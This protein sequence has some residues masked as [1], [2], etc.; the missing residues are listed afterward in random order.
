MVSVNL[1]SGP[2]RARGFTLVE[3]LVVIAIIGVLVALLLPAVQAA[4]E[5]ARRMTC[6]NN[7]KQL[8]LAMNNYVDT[9]KA[10]PIGVQIP[11]WG[12]RTIGNWGW[13]PAIMPQ[14]ELGN[15]AEQA[16]YG[17]VPM[18][19][20]LNNSTGQPLQAMQ[21]RINAF[22]CP[23]GVNPASHLNT[24]F[25]IEGKELALSN[26][27]ANN[28]SYSFRSRLGNLAQDA[29]VDT[30]FNNGMFA[31]VGNNPNH[32]G[33]GLRRLA[34]VTDGTSNTILLGERSWQTFKVDYSAAVVWGML[35]HVA[36][37]GADGDGYLFILGCGWVH[38]NS[39]AK[40]Y[41]ANPNHRRGFSSNHPGGAQ[42]VLV[43]GSTHFL[44][45]NIDHNDATS[46]SQVTSTY[47]KLL[48]ADD[49]G[50]VNAF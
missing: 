42:F 26:Y 25:K 19:V 13:A 46:S 21:Q 50:T 3:L 8:G 14:M 48:A 36:A 20:A 9:L 6:A 41:N 32:N 22:R 35:G 44:N 47:S 17:K 23:S 1:R 49:G 43:D 34:E 40:P 45:E 31:E 2:G 15:L 10:F 37:A 27:V 18:T 12:N 16:L 33:P 7:L 39:V 38:L 28:G 11:Q 4:R 24:T 30:G 5:A 29:S